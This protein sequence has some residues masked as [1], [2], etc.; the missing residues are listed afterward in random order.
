MPV[1]HDY[2]CESCGK[3]EEAVQPF[4]ERQRLC[5][6]WECSGTAHRIFSYS[7]NSR[8]VDVFNE[9][10]EEN[11]GDDMPM[12]TSKQHM[13]KLCEERGLVSKYLNDGYRNYG[14][15]REI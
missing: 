15:R 10:R 1:L 5:A 13:A 9:Y 11:L 12:V 2:E 8:S 7:K 14:R 6:D 4:E 3:I